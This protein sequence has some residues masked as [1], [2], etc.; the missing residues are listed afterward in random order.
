MTLG[1]DSAPNPFSPISLKSVELN[2]G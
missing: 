2:Q 1:S